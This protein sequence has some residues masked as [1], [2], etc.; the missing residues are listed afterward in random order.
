MINDVASR[1]NK[2]FFTGYMPDTFVKKNF[3]KKLCSF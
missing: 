1:E 2:K 3:L